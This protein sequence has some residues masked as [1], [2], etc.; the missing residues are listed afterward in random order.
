MRIREIAE[1]P[2]LRKLW[3]VSRL[4]NLSLFSDEIRK[5]TSEQIDIILW[6]NLLDNPETLKKHDES[7]YDPDFDDELDRV[8]Q[9]A[10]E[11]SKAGVPVDLVDD[12]EEVT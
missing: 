5:L 7:Y 3:K 11:E 8:E 10:I 9:E 4:L 2:L 6:E 12:W 1:I